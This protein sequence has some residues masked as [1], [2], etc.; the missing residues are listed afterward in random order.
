MLLY[1]DDYQL[2]VINFY[3]TKPATLN[4]SL[5]V[6]GYQLLEKLRIQLWIFEFKYL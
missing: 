4:S 6:D 1:F 3:L 5:I 2:L